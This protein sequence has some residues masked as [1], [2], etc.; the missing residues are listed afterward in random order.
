ME[1]EVSML[2]KQINFVKNLINYLL[3]SNL[4]TEPVLL[5]LDITNYCNLQCELCP[6]IKITREK[7]YMDLSLLKKIIEQ[8][9]GAVLEYSIG[10]HGEP[11]LHPD[12][13]NMIKYIK[14]NNGR[15]MINSNLNYRNDGLNEA[16]VRYRV[17]RIHVNIYSTE[18]RL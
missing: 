18:M 8:T 10:V 14:E 9:R 6:N 3:L 2:N 5:E 12:L 13:I 1:K 11:S 17:D 15:M 7:G 16:L 4:K